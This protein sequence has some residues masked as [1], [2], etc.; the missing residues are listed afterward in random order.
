MQL[1]GTSAYYDARDYHI[2][3]A[4]HPTGP[5]GDTCSGFEADSELEG[6]RFV[7]FLGLQRQPE[8]PSYYSG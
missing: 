4:V 6:K 3:C 5:P 8:V 1:K 2:V 7:D